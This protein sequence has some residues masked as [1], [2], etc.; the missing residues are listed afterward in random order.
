MEV[1]V[2]PEFVRANEVRTLCGS[3][4]KLERVVGGL[5][6]IPLEDTLS[7]MLQD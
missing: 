1:R 5:K 7:W 3:A 4:E 6:H 2:N